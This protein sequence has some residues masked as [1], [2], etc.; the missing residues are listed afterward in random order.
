M[1][2][3]N[4]M[5]GIPAPASTPEFLVKELA[6]R[7]E[8]DLISAPYKGSGPLIGDMLG[9]QIE[10]GIGSVPDFLKYH[11]EGKLRALAVLGG[12]RQPQL[13]NVPTLCSIEL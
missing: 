6:Q 9:R 12:K 7:Y 3:I 4:E 2:T 5:S 1:G 10:A 11:Q 13:P 8:L